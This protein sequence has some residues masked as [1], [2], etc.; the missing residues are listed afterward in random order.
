MRLRKG[1]ILKPEVRV[2]LKKGKIERRKKG[3]IKSEA[4]SKA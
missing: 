2:I 3:K 4:L 1:L